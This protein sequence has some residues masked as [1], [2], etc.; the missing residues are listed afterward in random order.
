M[1]RGITENKEDKPMLEVQFY[2]PPLDLSTLLPSLKSS[3]ILP[4]YLYYP[5]P[6]FLSKRIF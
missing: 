2:S 1:D 3:A 6:N 5:K 4:Q